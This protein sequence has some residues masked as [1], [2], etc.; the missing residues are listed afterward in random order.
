MSN[1]RGRVSSETT[2]DAP[3][4]YRQVAR[5]R[6]DELTRWREQIPHFAI[7]ATSDETQRL[8][9]AAS[10]PP[11]FIELATV[12]M[13]SHGEL[14]RTEAVPPE[15]VSDLLSYS[16]AFT[17]VADELEALAKFL[18]YSTTAARHTAATE[19]LTTYALASRLARRAG[20]G[21]LAPHVADMRRALGRTGR[22]KKAPAP[23][24][25][26]KNAA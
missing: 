2:P 5:Q 25:P 4:D 26:A 1:V 24:D 9:I 15:H 21:K 19:A 16:Q 22:R 8:S 12:A 23:A 20:G 6:I 10:V 17:P 14:G 7:P 13:T 3:P 18:R 11:E